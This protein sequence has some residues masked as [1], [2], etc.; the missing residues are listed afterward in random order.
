MKKIIYFILMTIVSL[1]ASKMDYATVKVDGVEG[2]KKLIGYGIDIDRCSMKPNSSFDSVPVYINKSD[3]D[4]LKSLGYEVKWTPAN[5]SEVSKGYRDNNQIGEELEELESNYPEICK[6]LQIGTTVNGNPIW[7]MKITDNINVEEAEPEFKYTSSMHGDEIVPME[8]CMELIYDLLEGYEAENDTMTTLI[9]NTEIYIVP[10]HNPDGNFAHQRTNANGVDLNRN[11]P[12]RTHNDPNIVGGY[13][14]DYGNTTQPENEAFMNWF[15]E[16]NFVL[17][18]NFHNGAQVLNYPWDKA[19]SGKDPLREV[20]AATPDDETFIWLSHGYANRNQEM[21]NGGYENGII[22]GASWYQISGGLQD[23]NY[24]YHST[25]EVTAE[26]SNTKWPP[27]SEVAQHWAHNRSSMLWYMAAVHSGIKGIVTDQDGNPLKA[28]IRIEGIDKVFY[29]DSDFGDYQRVVAPG[30][31]TLI[32]EKEGYETFTQENVVV[33]FDENQIMNSTVVNAVLTELEDLEAPQVVDL[34]GNKGAIGQ[35]LNL[36]LK[37]N[38]IHIVDEVKATYTINGVTEEIDME[39]M[40]KSEYIYTA[41]IPAQSSIITGDISFYTKDNLGNEETFTGYE[42]SWLEILMEDFESGDFSTYSWELSGTE[43]W[44]IDSEEQSQGLYSARSGSITDNQ[45]TS[46]SVTLENLEAGT[47]T[48]DYKVSSEANYD[49]LYF[50]I[51]GEEYSS[52]S[53]N[54]DWSSAS[55][56]VSE[57]TH[58]FKWSY[59]KDSSVSG[60]SDCAWIDNIVFPLPETGISDELTPDRVSLSQNYPNPFNPT[61]QISFSIPTASNINLSIFNGNGQLV[62]TLLDT[63]MARGVHSVEFD[64]KDLNSGL[65]FYRLTT[66][67][68]TITKKMILIK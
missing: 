51:D 33:T 26:V 61:T 62:K 12:E 4:Y 2:I 11:Y 10:L 8:M 63:Q 56:D 35:N 6:R 9:N 37:L 41:E 14:D 48:F 60:N 45:E 39:P 22:N 68:E 40:E 53:G 7:G 30:T 29:S 24:A 5:Y 16:S 58:T 25:M 54:I 36:K 21:L 67:S 52:W 38:E 59:V 17:S 3:F 43:Q 23:F 49:K 34:S 65:Y 31:Y 47:I 20:Y 66:N 55:F 1:S 15:D 42:L 32:V 13:F 28:N 50:H 27:F 18:I 46:M 44:F 64:A 19:E 57:G